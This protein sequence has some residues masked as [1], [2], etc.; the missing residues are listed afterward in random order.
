MKKILITIVVT[1]IV[2]SLG[3]YVC[4]QIRK[5]YE[6]TRLSSAVKAPGRMALDTILADFEEGRYET[7]TAR[8]KILGKSWARFEAER[9][10][11]DNGIG[12]IMVEFRDMP[13]PQQ[14]E[15]GTEPTV[16]P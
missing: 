10:Y 12:N 3:W 6:T 8:L 13:T 15:Q 1:V 11:V 4:G 9:G 14:K 2:T 7:G 5:G 16:A